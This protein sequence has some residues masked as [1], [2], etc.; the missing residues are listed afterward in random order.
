MVAPLRFAALNLVYRDQ[1][2]PRRHPWR[3]CVFV[4]ADILV[5]ALPFRGERSGTLVVLVN[6][7]GDAVVSLP[8]VRQLRSHYDGPFLVLGD[9]S[10]RCLSGNLY[11]DIP[12]VFID[13]GRYTRSLRYRLSVNYRV[14]AARFE[15][16]VCFMHHR[17]EMRD[18][19]LVHVSAAPESIVGSLPFYH[20]RWY[21]WL[22]DYYLDRMSRI[23][24]SC[25]PYLEASRQVPPEG[26]D[27][28]RRVPHVLER[29]HAFASALGLRLEHRHIPA[30]RPRDG[31][32]LLN[33]GAKDATRH[34]PITEWAVLAVRIAE[35]GYRPCFVGGPAERDRVG[36]VRQAIRRAGASA[37]AAARI[38]T[39]VD[40]VPF[41][42]LV[43]RFESAACYIGPD[44]GTSHLAVQCGTPTVTILLR[45]IVPEE[46][47]FGDFFPY[48]DG[49][50][51]TPYRPVCTTRFDFRQSGSDAV[52]R[53]AVF[54]AFISIMDEA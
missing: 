23:V 52:L 31:T 21:P 18:D 48:P 30:E 4:L 3:W 17:L 44:T 14:R 42:E 51:K 54:K 22:F 13:E 41:A 11:A 45:P 7:L 43:E 16:A 29:Q 28:P 2:A 49:Y 9:A 36:E 15:R 40:E 38:R 5:R 6:R 34:W 20:L 35:L 1:R 24:E 53:D 32:V 8:L 25:P 50:L 39:L 26:C 19:A 10:W 47:R 33:F 12:T 46:D 37:S 27:Q